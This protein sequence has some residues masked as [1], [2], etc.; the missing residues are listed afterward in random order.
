MIFAPFALEYAD[1]NS[2]W[3]DVA[4][5]VVIVVVTGL[6]LAAQTAT[7][8]MTRSWIVAVVGLAL[9]IGPF[10]LGHVVAARR[11]E[12]IVGVALAVLG[13]TRA[14]NAGVRRPA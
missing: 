8:V 11:N 9:A 13:A 1:V 7:S 4:F 6:A 14:L 12:I 2:T 3:N 5:G 10:I